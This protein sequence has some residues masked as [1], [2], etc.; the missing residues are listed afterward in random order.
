MNN[1]ETNTDKVIQVIGIKNARY[2]FDMNTPTKIRLVKEVRIPTT[3]IVAEAG[4]FLEVA[5]SHT[6]ALTGNEV[7]VGQ[8][9]HFLS[10]V[11]PKAPARDVIALLYTHLVTES[12]G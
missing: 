7:S 8:L 2:S 3:D 9:K 5:L 12:Q 1:N 11:D 6:E 4:D 10:G